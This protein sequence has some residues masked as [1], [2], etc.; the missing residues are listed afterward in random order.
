MKWILIVTYLVANGEPPP[1]LPG[2]TE[3]SWRPAG[4]T[5]ETEWPEV[6]TSIIDCLDTG[7]SIAA[8]HPGTNVSCKPLEPK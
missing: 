5:V 3:E 6:F 7:H 8:K 1:L 4:Y 2:N